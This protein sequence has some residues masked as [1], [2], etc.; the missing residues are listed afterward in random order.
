MN[1]EF[2]MPKMDHLSEESMVVVWRKQTGE[3]V[4]KGEI[5]LEIE[6]D[7]SVLE[8]ESTVSGVLSK[9]LV[10]AGETVPVGTPLAIF[11]KGQ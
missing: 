3:Q 1:V 2:T 7:K 10:Q 6:T 4:T 11:Q 5:L 9:I 8:V